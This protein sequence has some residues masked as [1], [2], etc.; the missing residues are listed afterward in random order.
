MKLII[1]QAGVRRAGEELD[2][3]AEIEIED[4]AI[5]PS[6]INKAEIMRARTAI[7]NP[8]DGAVQQP[9][10][11]AKHRGRG[12]YSV[13]D[14]DGNE[15]TEGLS[16]EDAEAF[17]AMSLNERAAYVASASDKEA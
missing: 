14:A 12:S 5:P 6:L 15:V 3:G 2:I 10:Y 9:V 11:E 16:K 7:T 17:N 4:D 8:A 1:T 13:L